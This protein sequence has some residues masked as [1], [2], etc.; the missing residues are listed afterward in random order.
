VSPYEEAAARIEQTLS[1]AGRRAYASLVTAKGKAIAA[2]WLEALAAKHQGEALE[3]QL[4]AL[5]GAERIVINETDEQPPPATDPAM[6]GNAQRRETTSNE[7]KTK[8]RGAAGRSWLSKRERAWMIEQG[9]KEGAVLSVSQTMANVLVR[10]RSH[11]AAYLYLRALALNDEHP[12]GQFHISH[13]TLGKKLGV[14]ESTAERI[15]RALIAAGLLAVWRRGAELYKTANI[16]TLVPL[17]A[18][19]RAKA[20]AYYTAYFAGKERG[21]TSA[22]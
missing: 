4:R 19:V 2:M 13:T 8:K 5:C 12:P 7:K 16:Y 22:A 15:T 3:A 1:D 11:A 9:R 6:T 21:D 14:S 10:M 18:E 17:T 20:E